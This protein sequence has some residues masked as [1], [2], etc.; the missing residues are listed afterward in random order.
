MHPSLCRRLDRRSEAESK[1]RSSAE[2]DSL[3]W[4]HAAGPSR[5]HVIQRSHEDKCQ[6]EGERKKRITSGYDGRRGLSLRLDESEA[7]LTPQ[8]T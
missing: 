4:V 5:L 1:P 6:R 3:P 7:L 8:S 2:N